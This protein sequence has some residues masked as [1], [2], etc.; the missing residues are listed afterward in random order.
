MPLLPPFYLDTIVAIGQLDSSGTVAYTA[1]GFFY[2]YATGEEN[3]HS[4]YLVTNEHVVR[5]QKQLKVRPHFIEG[6]SPEIFDMNLQGDSSRFI[7]VDSTHDVAAISLNPALL[8]VP[9]IELTFIADNKRVTK[10]KGQ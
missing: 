7:E 8:E 10:E 6:S 3:R 2:G 9:G 5:G 1:T 4:I